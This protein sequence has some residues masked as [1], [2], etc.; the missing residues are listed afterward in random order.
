MSNNIENKKSKKKPAD[1]LEGVNLER[2]IYK[3]MEESNTDLLERNMMIITLGITT[4]YRLQDITDLTIGK[5]R[6][7]LDQGYF[8]LQEKKQL[9]SWETY[10]VK[11]PKSNRKKPEPRIAEIEN[12]L[13]MKL[14]KFVKGKKNSEYAFKAYRSNDFI[15]PESFS[16]FMTD[17]AKKIGLKNISGHSLRKTYAT[18]IWNESKDLDYV[19]RKLGHKSIEVT[20]RYL[21][22]Q[23]KESKIG[24]KMADKLISFM[25]NLDFF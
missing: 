1:A 13:E 9:K 21:G 2:F 17:T 23:N 14:R 24:A 10:K 20:R 19:R 3:V 4:G 15:K 5:I 7:S 18:K 12:N 6:E 8:L 16:E 25:K 22:L 11:Y